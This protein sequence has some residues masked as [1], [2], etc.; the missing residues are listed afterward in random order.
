MSLMAELKRR[1]VFRVGIAY[2]VLAWIVLQVGDTLAPA[3]HLPEWVNSVLVFFLILGF[4]LAIFFA[5]A[6]EMTPEG[7]KKEKD[8]NRDASITPVTGRKLDRTIIA[9][10]VVALAYFIWQSQEA[11]QPQEVAGT[12]DAQ[13]SIAVLPFINM[14]SD[15]EQE[16]FSDG[17]SEELLNLLAKIPDLRVASRTSAFSFKGKD[18]RIADVGE[19]LGVAHVLEGSVRK[20]GAK[21]RITAQ[22]I[23]VDSDA[24][25]WS[26]TWDR[27]MDDVFIIQDE[28]AQ[29]VVDELKVRLL[30][31][32]P[33]AVET[34]PET[35]SLFLQA[36]HTINQRT[37]ESLRRGEA[38]V[39]QA[40]EI[41][42][43]YAPAWALL[44]LIYSAQGDIA[45]ESPEI[46]FS[47]ARD[48]VLRALQLDP[49]LG[50][51]H[52]T[53]ADIMISFDRNYAAARSEF[54]LALAADPG[55]VDTLYQAAVFYTV[56]GNPEEGLRLSKECRTRDPLFA[57][58]NVALGYIYETLDQ[59]EDAVAVLRQHAESRPNASGSFYYLAGALLLAGRPEE[60]LAVID[61]EVMDGFRL[62]GQAIANFLAGKQEASDKAMA[63]LLAR[64]NEGWDYQ[65]AQAHAVRGEIDA[66]YAALDKG[67]DN[68][69]S[70]MQMVLGD[71]L[72]DNLRDD[73]RF[74]ALVER[75]GIRLY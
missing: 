4:P 6:F 24:H 21:I 18:I 48:A 12:T 54:E 55:D 66:A 75:M 14:S 50:P 31:A 30:G 1:N 73:P 3:L 42:P 5:W 74:E 10:L 28:I 40:I 39:R 23:D 7:L 9:L 26:E 16:Y 63:A 29:A 60:A 44:A 57:P 20:S 67:L 56:T 15:K 8:V 65:L 2:V 49:D 61:K 45:I 17:L 33:R 59:Y 37:P 13:E 68:H 41:D 27:T 38:L 22:L 58:N 11:P 69:D 70:G 19:E 34:K 36:R 71:G 53:L 47:K 52:A 25:L 32:V 35:F 64:Q 72:L 46:V 51:A 62:T 43:A